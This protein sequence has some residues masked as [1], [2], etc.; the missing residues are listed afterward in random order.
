VAGADAVAIDG[1]LSRAAVTPG[2]A[3]WLGLRLKVASGYHIN[4]ARPRQDYLIPTAVEVDPQSGFEVVRMSFPEAQD[5][6]APFAEDVLSVYSGDVLVGLELRTP[7]DAEV[8]QHSVHLVLRLQPCDDQ[9]CYPPMEARMR[10]LVNVAE[11]PG[12]EQ[13]AE[14]FAEIRGRAQ[15]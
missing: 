5:Y 9:Q 12:G 10:F 1:M 15:S 4:S 7:A 11:Q 13:F 14:A 2:E 6:Q 8:G 3:F